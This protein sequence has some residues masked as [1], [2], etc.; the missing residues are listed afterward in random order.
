VAETGRRV[1]RKLNCIRGEFLESAARHLLKA[2]I[3]AKFLI[4]VMDC[5]SQEMGELRVA[6]IEANAQLIW[7][8]AAQPSRTNSAGL[9]V[10]TLLVVDSS[11][12]ECRRLRK[13]TKRSCRC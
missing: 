11:Y 12:E 8:H 5:H 7:G 9:G 13:R 2:G 3:V 6:E 10:A 1:G 4:L